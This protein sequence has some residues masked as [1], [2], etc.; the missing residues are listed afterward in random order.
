MACS[1]KPKDKFTNL[2]A[3]EFEKLIENDDVQRLDVRTV[4]EYSE[5]HIPGSINI[6]IFD[7][8]FSAAADEILDKSRPVAVYCKSGRRSRNAARLLVKKGYTVY[9]LDKGI[10]NWIDLGKDIEK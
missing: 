6:N 1:S 8:K 10:L 7:D 2:S 3:D 4:A 9:N 5:G